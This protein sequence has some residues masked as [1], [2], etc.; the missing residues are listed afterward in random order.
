MHSPSTPSSFDEQQEKERF[1]SELLGQA[2]VASSDP[3]VD[4]GQEP[5]SSLEATL[6]AIW[7][8]SFARP[9]QVQDNYFALGG[10]SLK[11]IRISARARR[12][13]LDVTMQDIINHP[14]VRALAQHLASCDASSAVTL[15][16]VA[17]T[18]QP[19]GGVYPSTAAQEGMLYHCLATP[20]ASLYV[21]QFSCEL[22][23]PLEPARFEAALRLLVNRHPAL[24][25]AFPENLLACRSQ[26]IHEDVALVLRYESPGEPATD[27]QL[28]QYKRREREQPFDLSRPPLLRVC[29]VRLSAERHVWIWTQHHLI[30]DGRAQ[31]CLMVELA[32]LYAQLAGKPA[33]Q[34]AED[35]SYRH[36]LLDTQARAR[37]EQSFWA[38]YLAH[39]ECSALFDQRQD[40]AMPEELL[41]ELSGECT[42][43]LGVALA[44]AQVTIA[45][46]FASWF[47]F[48]FAVTFERRDLLVGLVTCGRQAERSDYIDTVGNLISTLPLRATINGG[49][50]LKQWTRAMQSSIANLQR[51]AHDS[52]PEIKRCV[53]WP[54]DSALFNAIYVHENHAPVGRI[55]GGATGLQVEDMQFHINEGYPLVLVCEQAQGVRF[56]L[57]YQPQV[58]SGAQAQA[59]LNRLS[60]LCSV[61]VDNASLDLSRV[62][63]LLR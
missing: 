15:G 51:H 33:L 30:A 53:G 24:R 10:D 17:S 1:V 63:D 54:A 19:Q 40:A 28:L 20:Q 23:G 62:V 36:F 47:A 13:G 27:A 32:E 50:T 52:L 43:A 34:L 59:L 46:A 21:S 49:R 6:L 7:S 2:Q 44:D 3:G 60:Q 12:A 4:G 22:V 48:A 56:T 26:R 25:T 37:R 8:E 55:F 16:R 29:L 38:D 11:S 31:E 35:P 45:S 42:D 5:L 14:T 41:L 58:C 39:L 57:R 18:D 9:V 61:W